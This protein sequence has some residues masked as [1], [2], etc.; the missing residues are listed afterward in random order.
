MHNKSSDIWGSFIAIIVDST[1]VSYRVLRIGSLAPIPS[2]LLLRS[3]MS[4]NVSRS[5]AISLHLE[6]HRSRSLPNTTI[7]E[8]LD[9]LMVEEWR[10]SPAYPNYFAACHPKECTYTV[11][12]R[13]DAIYI[14][15]T[16]IG[17]IGGLVTILKLVI[18]RAVSLVMYILKRSRRNAVINIATREKESVEN[19]DHS[20][21][22]RP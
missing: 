14:V 1:R 8:I 18:P 4:R 10:W 12:G 11:I 21:V 2:R 20:H 22:D 6:Y 19:L 9:R 7:N 15:T 13:N 5:S 3:I 16:V 17:L